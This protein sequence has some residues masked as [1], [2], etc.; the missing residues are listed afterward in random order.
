MRKDDTR[1]QVRTKKDR[2]AKAVEYHRK[3]GTSLSGWIKRIHKK[4]TNIEL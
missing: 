3:N 2:K 1:I 4:L